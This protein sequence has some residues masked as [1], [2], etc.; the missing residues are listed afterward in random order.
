[1]FIIRIYGNIT[2]GFDSS[3]ML[4]TTSTVHLQVSLIQA[5]TFSFGRYKNSSSS[6]TYLVVSE[7]K[8]DVT[9]GNDGT[10]VFDCTY[11]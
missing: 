9:L 10:L 11:A 6:T 7:N 4:S 3:M 8:L 5:V 1:M 2:L